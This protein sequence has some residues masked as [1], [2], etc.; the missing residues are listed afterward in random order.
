[1]SFININIKIKNGEEYIMNK[2]TII[3]NLFAG[4][5]AGKTTSALTMVSA[6][7]REGIVAEYIPEY[8][9][10]LVNDIKSF[11]LKNNIPYKNF[12]HSEIENII[13]E[14]KTLI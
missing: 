1:M 8:P 7:K 14:I 3:I 5:S 4:P 2:N 10:E 11:L 13:L 9:K 12:K 6:L